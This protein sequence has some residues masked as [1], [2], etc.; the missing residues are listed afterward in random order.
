MG[1]LGTAR[2]G[3]RSPNPRPRPRSPSQTRRQIPRARMSVHLRSQSHSENHKQSTHGHH[4]N[5]VACAVLDLQSLM[6]VRCCCVAKP[7]SDRG[8]P[9]S[10][11]KS[12]AMSSRVSSRGDECGAGKLT[13]SRTINL[14]IFWSF[15]IAS[16]HNATQAAAAG[17]RV[18]HRMIDR[19]CIA[20]EWNVHQ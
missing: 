11:R 17:C 3:W 8:S 15:D 1:T 16:E 6:A 13:W 20:F 12:V 7:S 5:L 18:L 10:L 19:T 9:S 2:R 4:T 14:T